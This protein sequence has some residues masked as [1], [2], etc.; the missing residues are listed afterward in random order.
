MTVFII[1]AALLV[2]VTIALLFF[3]L[4]KRQDDKPARDSSDLSMQVLREQMQEVEKAQSSGQMD[5]AT[6]EIEKRELE[7]RALEDNS[8][9]SSVPSAPTNA[10]LQRKLI[11]AAVVVIP[12]M[13]AGLYWMLGN[14]DTMK[15]G[16]TT[17]TPG[18]AGGN[19]SLNP[20]QIAEM[21]EKLSERLAANPMDG[22]GWLMLGRS[23]AAIGR[24]PEAAAALGRALSILP[25]NPNYLADYAD[26]LAMAQGRRLSGEPE[27]AIAQALSLDPNHI[28]ALALSGSAAFEKG[29]FARAVSEWQK[30]LMLVPPDSSIAQGMKNSINDAQAR[31][32]SSGATTQQAT[33][34][35][36]APGT[37]SVS[38]SVSIADAIK[39][40]MSPTD[41]VFIFARP[42]EGSRMPLALRRMTVSQLPSDF[43]LDDS[44]AM[45][46]AAKLSG[47]KQV[48]IGARITK[49]GS[50]TPQPGDFEGVSKQPV[51]VGSKGVKLIID[52]PVK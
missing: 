9:D 2:V 38:G 50:A 8:A 36:A 31:M 24:H 30:I 16:G 5:A 48:I 33:T 46:P 3:P 26:I 12:L 6:A 21:A 22:E 43:T 27:K 19:H 4:L 37:A 17:Q 25:P 40:Q 7:R 28:K 11:I 35:S 45:M 15:P 49:T 39:G 42:T 51:K 13:A 18:H 44:M 34:P 32:G 1:V 47:V 23:Y 10:P 29:D 20:Q 41:T 14:P 52:T